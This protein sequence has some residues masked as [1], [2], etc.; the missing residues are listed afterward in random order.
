MAVRTLQNHRFPFH[1]KPV[2]VP[3]LHRAKAKPLPVT[4]DQRAVLFEPDFN[5]VKIRRLG[6]PGA[7][8]NHLC[9]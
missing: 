6:R 4:M 3:H 8:R 9:L 5:L 7:R 1:I 2:A